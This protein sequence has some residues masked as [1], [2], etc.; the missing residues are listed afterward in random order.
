MEICVTFGPFAQFGVLHLLH[1][2]IITAAFDYLK[3][4]NNI[5]KNKD[6]TDLCFLKGTGDNIK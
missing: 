5:F 2:L 4:L 6:F 1:F 3:D